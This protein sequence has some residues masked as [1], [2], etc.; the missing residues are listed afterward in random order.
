MATSPSS[1]IRPLTQGDGGSD[2]SIA[3]MTARLS[4]DLQSRLHRVQRKCH[5]G[6]GEG[7]GGWETGSA[8]A[9]DRDR[10]AKRHHVISKPVSETVAAVMVKRYFNTNE[11]LSLPT[12]LSAHCN[13]LAGGELHLR[14]CIAEIPRSEG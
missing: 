1:N 13:S 2:D 8:D 4:T 5:C 7:G 3:R 6:G 14:P 11:S 10:Y 9:N 12:I